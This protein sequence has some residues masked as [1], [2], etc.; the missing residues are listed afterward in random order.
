MFDRDCY[1]FE[2]SVSSGFMPKLINSTQGGLL[3]DQPDE[4]LGNDKYTSMKV[5]SVENNPDG[6]ELVVEFVLYNKGWEESTYLSY[7]SKS[8][9]QW[10]DLADW[11][12]LLC[13]GAATVTAR[14]D[15]AYNFYRTGVTPDGGLKFQARFKYGDSEVGHY[16][17]SYLVTLPVKSGCNPAPTSINPATEPPK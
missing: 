12:S 2:E 15:T 7:Y 1:E 13:V 14:E 11:D 5:N 6:E 16:T 8:D 9:E 10:Y 17:D 3:Y 4:L